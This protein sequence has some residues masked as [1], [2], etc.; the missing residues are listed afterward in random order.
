[1][2]EDNYP[3]DVRLD[4]DQPDGSETLVDEPQEEGGDDAQEASQENAK[5]NGSTVITSDAVVAQLELESNEV[6]IVERGEVETIVS[7]G[8]REFAV[9]NELLQ[10]V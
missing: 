7:Q 4:L 10:E 5:K 2:N 9:G 6:T 8:D 1:M 3:N